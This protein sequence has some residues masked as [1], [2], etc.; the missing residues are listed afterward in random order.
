MNLRGI[1]YFVFV[2]SGTLNFFGDGWRFH[3]FYRQIFR[4]GFDFGGATFV[5]KTTTLNERKGNMELDNNLQPCSLFPD[6]VRVY[7]V[8][9]VVLNS[10]GLSGP[11]ANHLFSQGFWQKSREPFFISF[12]S[13]E[14]TKEQRIEEAKIFA[15]IFARELPSFSTRVG[16]ELNI[17]CPNTAHCSLSL[18]DDAVDQLQPFSGLDIPKIIKVNALTPI[19]AIVRIAASGLCDAIL[20]SNTIP[21]GQLPDKIDWRKIFGSTVSPL[22]HLGGGGLSGYPL[23]PIIGNW[24]FEAKEKG[25]SVPIIGGGGILRA[26]DVDYLHANGA[27]A[28]SIGTVAIIRPWRVK[29]IIERARQLYGGE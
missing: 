5:S 14:A 13:V 27:D 9:G 29:G 16:L 11:G 25:V 26:S 21:W 3:K 28:V 6:C 7:P 1:D 19:E 8:K 20:V 17:S 2:A 4:K 15:R 23:L 12:M 18:I 22:R 10:V 24:I